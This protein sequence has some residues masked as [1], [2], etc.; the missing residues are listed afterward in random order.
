MAD[1][2]LRPKQLASALALTLATQP[3][4]AADEW[5]WLCSSA[6][7]YEM[8][9]RPDGSYLP[10]TD[11]TGD[12]AIEIT[13]KVPSKETVDNCPDNGPEL[14]YVVEVQGEG[15]AHLFS[16]DVCRQSVLLDPD[17]RLPGHDDLYRVTATST[18]YGS[19]PMSLFVD[20]A[21]TDWRFVISGSRLNTDKEA[22]D[23]N[24]MPGATHPGVTYSAEADAWMMTGTCKL[25]AKP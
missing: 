23:L 7:F 13:L 14:P 22:R 21:D 10:Q 8:L 20:R 18:W 3:V 25:V 24:A 11:F 5:R 16:K 1:I 19:Q 15:L 4:S 9:V 6:G 12:R 2:T 17:I